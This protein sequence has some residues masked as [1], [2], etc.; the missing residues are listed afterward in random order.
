MRERGRDMK[1]LCLRRINNILR[2]FKHEL[3]KF[4]DECPPGEWEARRD[5]RL[6]EDE[7]GTSMVYWL[8]KR[9]GYIIIS[10]IF[11]LLDAFFFFVFFSSYN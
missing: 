11:F 6:T 9:H 8:L 7:W 10:Y 5:R 2:D 4:H 3:K 1:D